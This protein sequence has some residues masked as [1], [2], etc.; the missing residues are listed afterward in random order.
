LIY[1]GA[2][3][4]I[5]NLFMGGP[6]K[7]GDDPMSQG[8]LVKMPYSEVTATLELLDRLGV[9]PEDFTVLRK[10][11]SWQQTV[12]AAVLAGD[13]FLLGLLALEIPM[14]KAGITPK[15]LMTLMTHDEDAVLKMQ[16]ASYPPI[17]EFKTWR[18]VKLGM[19]PK[20]LPDFRDAFRRFN[21]KID[22]FA[23]DLL[24][25]PNFVVSS[26]KMEIELVVI[27]VAEL[28]FKDGATRA[29]IYKRAL[30]LGLELCPCEVGPQLRL[31][32]LDQPCREWLMIGAESIVNLDN[33]FGVF[34]IECF[35]GDGSRWLHGH[36]DE[37]DKVW[38]A[39]NHWVF[40]QRKS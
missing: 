7:K 20:S 12:T 4:H 28:G 21:C 29:D 19:G 8:N 1:Q 35:H 31:Q 30:E 34:G 27:S 14:K 10:A 26:E 25:G 23:E 13:P 22:S 40:V 33:D 38:H 39:D 37:P 2:R 15:G 36:R 24:Y 16:N 11:A 17:P 6:T 9:T 3:W 32:Y 18:T 5:G